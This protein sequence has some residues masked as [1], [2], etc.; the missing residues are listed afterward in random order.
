MLTLCSSL[1]A[2]KCPEGLN[3]CQAASYQYWTPLGPCFLGQIIKVCSSPVK[4]ISVLGTIVKLIP[5]YCML[6]KEGD[7]Q[8]EMH[9]TFASYQV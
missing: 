3:I 2:A 8:K 7:L 9:P 4:N 6:S 1:C 5:C